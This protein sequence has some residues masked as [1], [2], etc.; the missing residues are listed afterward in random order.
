MSE[1]PEQHESG[2]SKDV[3]K[4]DARADLSRVGAP[5]LHR[6]MLAWLSGFLLL[7]LVLLVLGG[8]GVLRYTESAEF[9]ERARQFVVERIA[10]TTGGRV[11]LQRVSWS[12]EQMQFVLD[13]LVIHGTEAKEEIPLLRVEEVHAQLKWSALLARRLSLHELSAVHPL[14]HVEVHKDGS[15]NLPQPK[16]RPGAP[17]DQVAQLL[18]LAVDR[19]E[20]LDGLLLWNEKKIKLNGRAEGIA[21]LLHYSPKDQHY[22]GAAR[23]GAVRIML[24]E[25]EPLTVGVEAKFRLYRDRLEVPQLQLRQ[26]KS[27]VEAS[28]ALTD[29]NSPVAQY[30]YRASGDVAEIGKLFR[31]TQLRGGAVLLSGEGT[32]RRADSNYALVGKAQAAGV[33]WTD[34]IVRLE[35]MSG[36]FNY[37]LDR[38]NFNVSSIFVIALGGT[39]HGKL[40][41][42]HPAGK[43]QAG[44]IALEVSGVD[45]SQT[46]RAFTTR[47]LPLERLHISGAT[48]GTLDVYW[49]GSFLNAKMDGDVRVRPVA[50]AG[51]LP[52]TAVVQ[53]T[54]DFKGQ[55]GQL[56]SVE[57]STAASR[58]SARGRLSANSDLRLDVS[59]TDCSEL[60]PMVTSWRGSRARVLP[61][62]F[63]GIAQ[64]HGAV[65]GN[66]SQPSV[67]GHLELHEFTT[68]LQT[69]EKQSGNAVPAERVVRTR[70][71]SLE[72]EVEYSSTREALHN[73]VLRRGGARIALDISVPLVAGSY[74]GGQPF[75]AHVKAENTDVADLQAIAGSE[76]PVTGVVNA[77][78]N[79]GGTENHLNGSGR[80]AIKD[81]TAWQQAVRL[82]TA[83][84]NFT[85]NQAQLRNIVVKSDAMQLA[86][87]ARI[88]IETS[89]F[90]FDL[91]GTEVKLENLRAVRE[92]KVRLTGQATFEASGSG[93]PGAPVVNGRLRL[94]NLAVNQHFIGD[95]N[96]DA[97]THGAEMLL[98][99]RSNFKSADVHLDG[100]VYL[101]GEMPMHISGD[102]QSTNLNSVLDAFLP[103]HYGAAS[104][105]KMHIDASGEARRP[106]GMTAEAVV[107]RW[108]SNY[109]GVA[110]SNDGP[111]RLKLVNQVLSVEQFRI[112]GEQGTRFLQLHGQVQLSGKRE[113]DLRADGSVN[114][115]LLETADPTLMAGGVANF[116][117][118]V[119]GTLAR[120]F[121][122][123][124]LN[125]QNGAIAY[126]DFPNGLSDITGTLVFN[127]DRLQV[128]E[129]TAR[130]GGGLLHCGGFIAFSAAQGIGF[131]LSASGHDIRL[132]YPE[133]LSS[134][135][136]ASLSLSGSIKN[137]ALSGNVT[138]TRLG[139]NPQFDFANYLAKGIR[140]APAQKI[141]SPLNDLHLDV[142]ITS[143]PE[144]QVQTSLARLSGNVDLRMRGTASRPVVL[145]RVNLLEG[146]LYFNGTKY[147]M[148][149][150]DVTLTNPVRIEPTLDVELSARVRDYDISLGFHGPLNKLTPSYRSDPPLSSSDIISLLALGRTAEEQANPAMMGT[151]QYQPS[152]S[153]SAST[154]LIGQALNATVSSR[155]QRLFGVSRLKIDPNVSGAVN[156]GLARVTVEQ[157]VSNKLTLTYITNLN[158]SAQQII[159]FEYNVDKDVSIVGVRDQTGVVSIDV[160]FRKRKK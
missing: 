50:R 92:G 34:S 74:D 26:G 119:N 152:V 57:A 77:D 149:R 64:F 82:A 45:L 14:A 108:T 105:L 36:G 37:S 20:L 51:E 140:G 88:N 114:L 111:I 67:A 78:V 43:E 52:V 8:L 83:D 13:G 40:D 86:G 11:E 155:V 118:Q 94:R 2:V 66:L 58:L 147:R 70:W 146:M 145:G 48:A 142:H 128:Q 156:A 110:V 17:A 123:G 127:E 38:E 32:W 23:V 158:Q 54:V 153:E 49:R 69:H 138:V 53:A 109:G 124:Q 3:Q 121:M 1:E 29:L 129:L 63:S 106:R 89:E 62:E 99:A 87:D 21:L 132:R 7:L 137:A 117:L 47:D 143:T 113:I 95:M 122:R 68:L 80:V 160:L 27:W 135:A 103:L 97:V 30:A 19:G 75:S 73:G 46:L 100:Q 115:K 9:H 24:P 154:A 31:L 120:P 33:N 125:V 126:I 98:T 148:E 55:S 139:L 134:T 5:K 56:H 39:V 150:G 60:E 157:Q 44:R 136:D 15:T 159:Q 84:V 104:E 116:N 133:G 16:M 79:V 101:R 61:I 144:L 4:H 91:K 112:A 151:S 65:Q 72:G 6:R 71:Q 12:L 131:N 41:S 42:S 59:S 96:V 85:E 76:Y 93:T 141:D 10:Q 81:G 25:M 22:E 90:G 28:G 18:R 35:H 107:E 130:T 102:A